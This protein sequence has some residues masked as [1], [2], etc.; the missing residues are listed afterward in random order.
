MDNRYFFHRCMHQV[1]LIA[2]VCATVHATDTPHVVVGNVTAHGEAI[3][4][5]VNKGQVNIHQE[6]HHHYASE[7]SALSADELEQQF[8]EAQNYEFGRGDLSPNVPEA[9][10]RYKKLATQKH[11]G[12][13]HRLAMLYLSGN[14]IDKNSREG[15]RLLKL[16]CDTGYAD[17]EYT[18]SQIYKAGKHGELKDTQRAYNFLFRAAL[19]EH[20]DARQE[21]KDLVMASTVSQPEFL[22]DVLTV[23][24]SCSPKAGL[25][26]INPQWRGAAWFSEMFNR[27]IG[28]ITHSKLLDNVLYHAGHSFLDVSCLYKNA[29][30]FTALIEKG[31]GAYVKPEVLIAFYQDITRTLKDHPN[32]KTISD[33]LNAFKTLE[34][35]NIHLKFQMAIEHL[36]GGVFNLMPPSPYRMLRVTNENNTP[37]VDT[38]L[39]PL[40]IF[41]VDQENNEYTNKVKRINNDGRCTVARASGAGYTLY[42]KFFPEIPG[43][44]AAV[45][46]L[47]HDLIGFGAPPSTLFKIPEPLRVP[48]LTSVVKKS[49]WGTTLSEDETMCEAHIPNIPVLVSLGIEGRMLKDVF[50][51]PIDPVTHKDVFKQLDS[52][53]LYKMILVAMLTNPEDGKS[54]NYIVEFYTHANKEQKYRI[55]GID[56]DHAFVPALADMGASH[57]KI[58]TKTILYAFDEITKPIPPS[59][60][61][62]FK[63]MLQDMD[64]LLR[65][66]LCRLR[67][68]SHHHEILFYVPESDDLEMSLNNKNG[69]PHNPLFEDYHSFIGIPFAPH[70]ISRL[71]TKL[72]KLHHALIRENESS[73]KLT[74]LDLFFE[75]EPLLKGRYGQAL[76]NLKHM[77]PYDRFIEI[78]GKAA[79][80]TLSRSLDVLTSYDIPNDPRSRELILKGKAYSPGQA[81]DELEDVI[82]QTKEFEQVAAGELEAFKKL[83]REDHNEEALK[84]IDFKTLSPL[85]N[86]AYLEA[87][88]EKLSHHLIKKLTLI[89]HKTLKTIHLKNWPASVFQDLTYVALTGCPGI[90]T[91]SVLVIAEKMTSVAHL[92]LSNNTGITVVAAREE[93]V[94]SSSH[95][96]V[97]KAP[98][99]YLAVSNCSSLRQMNVEAPTLKTLKV[100][101]C[102]RL[103]FVK[104]H[105]PHLLYVD[106]RDTPI[107]D[108][109]KMVDFLTTNTLFLKGGHLEIKDE[110]QSNARV[111]IARR[112][113][114]GKLIYKPDPKSDKGKIEF[115]IADLSNPL[116]GTF[117]LSGCGDTGKYIS[118]ATGYRKSKLPENAAKVEVWIVPKFVVEK[119]VTGP[120]S[121]Y[122]AVINDWDSPVGIFWAWGGDDLKS[123]DYLINKS[124]DEISTKNLYDNWQGRTGARR[125]GA[126]CVGPLRPRI[127]GCAGRIYLYF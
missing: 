27:M 88:Q 42:F 46:S 120:A 33:A 106:I 110:D 32:V 94:V 68:I 10:E 117:D 121:H 80:K 19:N 105:F 101:G 13:R 12:A 65:S 34:Q 83:N 24:A 81:T 122:R 16:A 14:G 86:D 90:N 51:Q 7:S 95:P 116:E 39:L 78:E 97:F 113:L 76:Q 3:V 6:T 96:I 4:I 37:H 9:C 108:T 72:V 124:F 104:G 29:T 112:F 8:S 15:L 92:D 38:K 85:V 99:T 89:K 21:F 75:L 125:G 11:N 127:R 54:D 40:S 49:I 57:V 66:W 53:S 82:Q 50:K 102:E 5:P 35:R 93:G 84:N 71:Y 59:V 36:C 1:S 77:S 63:E 119:N 44:E 20:V 123:Y 45:S 100:N 103:I 31:A 23:L 41:Q 126:A 109:M 60:C 64:S 70:T 107:L 56:N 62:H 26:L 30:A 115:P 55:I 111:K 73:T 52:D 98:L 91:N 48:V 69:L 61:Q 22:S 58:N 28:N 18:I 87:L 114:N 47:T 17:A 118:I 67:E 25:H 43:I 74:P 79:H 2:L